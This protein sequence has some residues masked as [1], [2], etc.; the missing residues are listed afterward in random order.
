MKWGSVYLLVLTTLFG[1]EPPA[2]SLDYM[3][4]SNSLG[5]LPVQLSAPVTKVYLTDF[6]LT[7]IDSVD[8]PDGLTVIGG[9]PDSS[10]V[11]VKGQMASSMGL[12]RIHSDQGSVDVL[13]KQSQQMP[14]V[15]EWM[16]NPG[17][18]VTLFGS[19]N[20]WDKAAIPMTYQDSSYQVTL[21]L[22]PGNHQYKYLVNGVETLDA[23]TDRV[24]NGIGGENHLLAL[25]SGAKA[26]STLS[27]RSV[28]QVG[29]Q[30]EV[31]LDA[32][33]ED[34][35][36]IALWDSHAMPIEWMR[37]DELGRWHIR[38]PQNMG[39]GQRHHLRLYSHNAGNW[40][41]DVLIPFGTKGAVMTSDELARDDWEAATL[42]FMMV[43]RFANGDSSNDGGLN[44]SDVLPLADYMGGDL[45]GI[46]QQVDA[47]FFEEMGFNTIWL[48]PI[49]KNPQ[50]AWGLWNKGGVT[51]KFAGYHGYWPVSATLPDR[52][53]ASPAD[54]HDLLKVAHDQGMNVLLDYVGNHVHVDHPAYKAHPEWATNLYLPDG[55]MNTERWDSHRLTTWFDS[56]L[57]TLDLSRPEVVEP[58]T[59][60]ALVWLTDYGFDGYR[61]D[62]TKHV[63]SLYWRTLTKKL[64]AANK[65]GKRLFQIGETYGSPELIASYLSSGMMDAQFD[66]NTYDAAVQFCGDLGGSAMNLKSTLEASLAAYGHHHLMGNISGNQD[67][68]RFISLADRQ[69]RQ[70]EDSKLA[71]YTRSI[72]KSTAL[73]YQR[74]ALLHA[75]NHAIPGVPVVYYG[76]EYGMPG[77]NDPDN[78]RMMTFGPYSPLEEALRNQVKTLVQARG[79]TMAL[80]YGSTQCV[81]ANE[82]VL[83]ITRRY[84]NER[85]TIVL[86]QGPASFTMEHDMPDLRVLAG[87]ATIGSESFHV[88]PHQFVYLKSNH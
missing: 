21:T 70:D 72:G 22:S 41:N 47:G 32:L 8:W 87:D 45:K 88:G 18:Q 25:V 58:M 14:V 48:S 65:S 13:L 23:T 85:I 40:S 15:F 20:G 26:C 55:S 30:Q 61:H 37:L 86:N 57:P 36:V 49:G 38:M 53:M 60:S 81:A 82:H 39:S 4:S 52:R 1:C 9:N 2:S 63:H 66:F 76:D 6:V 75:F 64:K 84:L 29:N 42:Y 73:G 78:R 11:Q 69:V 16:G 3:A 10:T 33:P 35:H 56:F 79:S 28:N 71:G 19:F 31:V 43:D 59:D 50:G 12:M 7:A 44:R 34:Q 17:N 46:E 67:K 77:A 54:V 5:C 83:V 27:V 74:L 24:A 62:A 68:P 51:T 80:L